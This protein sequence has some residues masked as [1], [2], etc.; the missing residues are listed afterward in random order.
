MS[1]EED[2]DHKKE[3]EKE[4]K[5]HKIV[6][7]SL[8]DDTKPNKTI[9]QSQ[10]SV[11]DSDPPGV[12]KYSEDS[13]INRVRRARTQAILIGATRSDRLPTVGHVT[14]IIGRFEN[15]AN[16]VTSQKNKFL[17]PLSKN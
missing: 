14:N 13:W 4:E 3:D 6:I 16:K 12:S 7:R 1:K 2:I 9:S 8:S 10:R 11:S 15:C 5:F 17:R